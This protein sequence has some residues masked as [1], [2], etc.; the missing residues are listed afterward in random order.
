MLSEADKG[1]AADEQ[2]TRGVDVVAALELD[3][4]AFHDL[5]QGVL[6]AARRRC[7]HVPAGAGGLELVDFVDEDDAALGA[8]KSPLALSIRRCRMASIS[9]STTY[10]VC[11]S[12][13]ALAVTKGTSMIARQRFAEQ[14]LAGAGRADQQDVALHHLNRLN[15]SF[16]RFLEVGIDGHRQNFLGILLPDHV[17][18]EMLDD[19]AG[20]HGIP[21]TP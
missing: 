8:S 10:S 6:H 19:F 1:A 14:R 21:L 3:R 15:R 20:F 12:V 17:V 16:G 5:E 2:H 13:V 11:A 18:I 9:S 7:A 4:R